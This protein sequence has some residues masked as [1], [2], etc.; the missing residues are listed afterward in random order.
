M[1]QIRLNVKPSLFTVEDHVSENSTF[2]IS[3]FELI[4]QNIYLTYIIDSVM[5]FPP[6][7]KVNSLTVNIFDASG[8]NVKSLDFRVK[9]VSYEH[10]KL[11]WEDTN[12]ILKM[13]VKFEILD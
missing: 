6:F 12:N 7:K 5:Q 3:D 8:R 1:N 10:F 13:K 9:F 2:L 11:S 4:A